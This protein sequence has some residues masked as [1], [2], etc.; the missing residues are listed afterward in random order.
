MREFSPVGCVRAATRKSLARIGDGA[1]AERFLRRRGRTRDSILSRPGAG[2]SEVTSI[3]GRCSASRVAFIVSWQATLMAGTS[4]TMLRGSA[5]SGIDVRTSWRPRAPRECGPRYRST[6]RQVSDR[7]RRRIIAL[8]CRETRLNTGKLVAE[9]GSN[10]SSVRR[11]ATVLH[12]VGDRASNELPERNIAPD[13]RTA[14]D[15]GRSVRWSGGMAH[16]LQQF[17]GPL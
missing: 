6:S 3:G 16:F 2:S 13:C 14:C 15:V 4:G 5:S 1:R 11:A 9:I 8:A 12:K 10:S 7:G 17:T